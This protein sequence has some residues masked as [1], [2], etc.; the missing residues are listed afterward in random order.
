M[1]STLSVLTNWHAEAILVDG[2][3]NPAETCEGCAPHGM[4]Q[5]VACPING[6]VFA[7]K[8]HVR[9]VGMWTVHHAA[10][11]VG[12]QLQV[13]WRQEILVWEV[14]MEK[15]VFLHSNYSLI[16]Y[17]NNCWCTIFKTYMGTMYINVIFC[18]TCYC[19]ILEQTSTFVTLL[20]KQTS[21]IS[22]SHSGEYEDDSLL[23]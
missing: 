9:T 6:A 21:L 17:W 8:A 4:L 3:Q 7:M 14:C 18:I 20:L 23:E 12:H 16:T 22:G 2:F 10:W 5:I 11:Q 19:F 13:W 15:A 1:C